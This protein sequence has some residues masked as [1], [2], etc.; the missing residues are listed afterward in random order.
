MRGFVAQTLW[1]EFLQAKW[2]REILTKKFGET[3]LN[4]SGNNPEGFINEEDLGYISQIV[5]PKM[6]GNDPMPCSF[7]YMIATLDCL[8]CYNIPPECHGCGI[9]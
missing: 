1:E 7:V 4:S 5:L 8:G 9:R 6:M 2:A 3:K